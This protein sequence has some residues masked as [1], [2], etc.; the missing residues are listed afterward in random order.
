MQNRP[1]LSNMKPGNQFVVFG[2]FFNF[3]VTGKETNERYF[4]YED[5]VPPGGGPPP[6]THPDEEVFY[7]IEGDFEF[8][9]HDV[10]KPFRVPAGQIV[11]I[12]GDAVHTFKNVGTGMGRTLTILFPGQLEQYYRA[13]GT[14]V[15]DPGQIPDLSLQ[16]DYEKMDLSKAFALADEHNVRFVMAEAAPV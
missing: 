8:I 10:T 12:P 3:L 6:H 7:I 9:L 4:I 14:R 2:H 16:P 5:L 13:T 11:R 1:D 15:T